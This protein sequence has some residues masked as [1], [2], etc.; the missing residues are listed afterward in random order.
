[1]QAGLGAAIAFVEQIGFPFIK[2]REHALLLE[3]TTRLGEIP[4]LRIIGT[5]ASK[6]PILS[7]VMKDAHPSDIGVVVDR[8]GVAI[9]TGQHCAE[10][11][12]KH[13]GV[14]A[15]ARASLAFYNTSAEIDA[16]IRGLHK[17]RELAA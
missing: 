13:F 12:L 15:T 5:A 2:D 3:G 10:P 7:F 6:G 1:M 14:T 11:L 16:L 17:V 9:R 8:E 4:G